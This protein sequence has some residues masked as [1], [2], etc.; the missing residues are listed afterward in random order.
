MSASVSSAESPQQE[1]NNQRINGENDPTS[2]VDN[3]TASLESGKAI[4]GASANQGSS[5]GVSETPHPP[6]APITSP[7]QSDST[8]TSSGEGVMSA[9]RTHQGNPP[10]SNRG[11]IVSVGRSGMVGGASGGGHSP[12]SGGWNSYSN[13][14]PHTRYNNEMPSASNYG[15]YS[16]GRQYGHQGGGDSVSKTNLY[17]R[18]LLPSTTDR[19]L[20]SLCQGYGNIRSTKAIVDQLTNKC[21][22]YGFV[23]FEKPADAERAVANLQQTG[24]QAQ[25]AKV[26][27]S[28]AQDQDPTNLY[29]A[30][31]PE[32]VDENVLEG[33]VRNFGNVVSVRILRDSTGKSRNVGFCRMDSKEICERIIFDLNKKPLAP[34]QEP[35]LVKFAD[36]GHRKK[37]DFRNQHALMGYEAAIQPMAGQMM[38]QGMNARYSMPVTNQSNYLS[39]AAPAGSWPGMPIYPQV[40]MSPVNPVTSMQSNIIDPTT[41]LLAS[42][43]GQMQIAPAAPNYGM[44]QSQQTYQQ[45]YQGQG[46]IPQQYQYDMSASPPNHL[47]HTGLEEHNYQ[48]FNQM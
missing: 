32:Y 47:T 39:N 36:S 23:D 14:P 20:H 26:R 28:S 37:R 41:T 48:N 24:M 21:K 27:E 5:A 31:L 38:P 11:G 4:P 16:Q 19:D 13:R 17:I 9:P 40:A 12:S 7:G 30:N 22:G 43:L 15:N 33:L 25:M 29:M 10:I 18:G 45:I 44:Q 35:L 1:S 46:M 6:S 34:G 2:I 8:I 3:S 42:Q